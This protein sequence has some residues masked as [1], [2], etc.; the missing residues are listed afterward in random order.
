M[1]NIIPSHKKFNK[2]YENLPENSHKPSKTHCVGLYHM[3]VDLKNPW[4]LKDSNLVSLAKKKDWMWSCLLLQRRV[5]P[6]LLN[7]SASFRQPFQ[8]S[9][10]RINS[11]QCW[12]LIDNNNIIWMSL[13]KKTPI[14]ASV[15][16]FRLVFNL[17]LNLNILQLYDFSCLRLT[18]AVTNQQPACDIQ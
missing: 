9:H 8:H 15:D 14:K 12:Q 1:Y 11:M 16:L 4:I 3:L 7:N 6:F 13:I 5:I 17:R 2:R 18:P 10:P